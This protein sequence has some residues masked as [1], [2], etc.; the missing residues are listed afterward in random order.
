MSNAYDYTPASGLQAIASWLRSQVPASPYASPET[1]PPEPTPR[2]GLPATAPGQD[3]GPM[4]RPEPVYPQTSSPETPPPEP[5]PSGGQR[6]G[7]PTV[8]PGEGEAFRSPGE[9]LSIIRQL[10]T[11]L[12]QPNTQ[13]P[14]REGSLGT[15]GGGLPERPPTMAEGMEAPSGLRSLLPTPNT[16]EPPREGPLGTPSGG[17]PPNAPTVE[18][19]ADNSPML[20]EDLPDPITGLRSFLPKPSPPGA[21]S[22]GPPAA[23]AALPPAQAPAATP[24]AQA[25]LPPKPQVP[26]GA[27]PADMLAQWPLPARQNFQAFVPNSPRGYEKWGQD[28]PPITALPNNPGIVRGPS[29]PAAPEA[30]PTIRGAGQQLAQYAA[31]SVGLPAGIASRIAGLFTPLMD[32]VGG[33]QFSLQFGKAQAHALANAKARLAMNREYY[34]QQRDRML[35]AAEDSQVNHKKMLMEY[36]DVFQAYKVGGIDQEQAED[37]IRRLNNRFGHRNLDTILQNG[38]LGAVEK[39]LD[40]EDAK[41]RDLWSGTASLRQ[42]DRTRRT[43]SG[44]SEDTDLDKEWSAD[45]GGGRTGGGAGLRPLP[46]RGPLAGEG[47]GAPASTPTPSYDSD[48]D[49][50]IAK[51]YNLSPSGV[52]AAH[53]LMRDGKIPGMTP[54]QGPKMAPHMY[55]NVTTAAGEMGNRI[56]KIA[57]DR[58]L[59]AQKKLDAIREV[60]PNIADTIDGLRNYNIN[61]VSLGS[62]RNHL[63]RLASQVDGNYKEGFYGIA[64][65]YRDPNTKEGTVM[66]RTGTLPMAT[67]NVLNA[68]KNISE[69]DKIPKRVL[70]S[71]A[72]E[73]YTGD[74][75]YAQLYSALRMF[76]TDAVAVSMGTGTPRVTLVNDLI[77]HMTATG[78]PASIRA[79][80]LTD[81][82]TA[83][84]YINNTDKQ[85]QTETGQSRHAPGFLPENANMLDA[86]LRMNPYTGQVPSDAPDTLKGVG[87]TTKPTGKDRPSWLKPGQDWEPM[88]RGQ[89]DAARRWLHDNPN[90]PRAQQVREQMGLLP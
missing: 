35:D 46:V 67:L 40:W 13:E 22:V 19:T 62:Q 89:V 41:F 82:R 23:Q 44:V 80:L 78:S 12:P 14:P 79:Q 47:G 4:L 59:D 53:N 55:D 77:K 5:T 42:S 33:G 50:A 84:A 64:Q 63:T 7:A 36:G 27:K 58:D 10:L 32:L 6:G 60:D 20:R 37:A 16:Q 1:P 43:K 90:D 21:P 8:Q 17:L 57:S 69:T 34:E 72:A 24:P 30:Y 28:H 74:P 25:A 61:P 83:H 45:G 88:T 75:K 65:K 48:S 56:N 39:Y 38:G 11:M 29:M 9:I 49:A 54:G 31:P 87:R 66:Q 3:A 18:S 52:E 81:L 71:F 51:K 2:G 76:A 15:P 85:W 70:E 86:M 26:P 68:L 73:Y